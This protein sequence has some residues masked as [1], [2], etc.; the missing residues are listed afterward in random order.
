KTYTYE[1]TAADKR[2]TKEQLDDE[3]E[4]LEAKIKSMK[5]LID[6]T[7][8]R[9]KNDKIDEDKYKKEIEKFEKDLK[10]TESKIEA[11]KKLIE[12]K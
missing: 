3:I 8:R 10:I 7:E 12:N 1:I 11:Y 6:F 5:S 2:K 4:K 9:Y